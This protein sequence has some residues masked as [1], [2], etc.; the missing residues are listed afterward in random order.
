MKKVKALEIGD[1]SNQWRRNT[2]VEPLKCPLGK[3]CCIE[4]D[5]TY[6]TGESTVKIKCEYQNGWSH[7]SDG[8]CSL[9]KCTGLGYTLCNCPNS[10][11]FI[12]ED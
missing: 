2:R 5:Y 4:Y 3:E 9:K 8:G 12:K 1:Y 7:T 11:R 6:E 10:L